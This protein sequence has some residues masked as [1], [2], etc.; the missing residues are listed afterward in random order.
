MSNPDAKARNSKYKDAKQ[1][2]ALDKPIS[3]RKKRKPKKRYHLMLSFKIFKQGDEHIWGRYDKF[4]DAE[5][6]FN[7]I[8]RIH[9]DKTVK[10][11]DKEDNDKVLLS[12][13]EEVD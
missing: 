2:L 6:N 11:I 3:N 13:N 9:Q 1:S 7:K 5:N 8:L 4:T 12:Y 10:V